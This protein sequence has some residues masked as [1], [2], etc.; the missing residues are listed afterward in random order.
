MPSIRLRPFWNPLML[1]IAL[2]LAPAARAQQPIEQQMSPEQFKA[3]GLDKLTPQELAS[4]NAWMR[5]T[6]EVET[7]KAVAQTQDRIESENRGFLS[8]GKSD[9]I[10]AKIA[11]EFRGFGKGLTWTLDNGQQ[12]EQTDNA[13]LAGVRKTDPQVRIAPSIVGNHWYLQI[14]GY[15]TRATVRR[16]K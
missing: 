2:V 3:A 1:V 4:L 10:V 12:W 8:F 15:N 5:G 11:G 6:L 14:E 9:P 16:V 13:S 7:T